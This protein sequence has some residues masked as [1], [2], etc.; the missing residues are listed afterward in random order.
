MI[1]SILSI[2]IDFIQ[3]YR[4]LS[5]IFQ[6]PQKPDFR[7]PPKSFIFRADFIKKKWVNEVP[8]RAGQLSIFDVFDTPFLHYKVWS[9]PLLGSFFIDFLKTLWTSGHTLIF[10]DVFYQVEWYASGSPKSDFYRFF[11]IFLKNSARACFQSFFFIQKTQKCL[12]F[13]SGSNPLVGF[14]EVV[15]F[16]INYRFFGLSFY[17]T[18]P[19]KSVFYNILGQRL[20]NRP[21]L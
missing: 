2:F 16:S 5:P 6:K 15:I 21:F 10:F 12:F 9:N 1:L 4:F 17:V 8:P 20:P 13:N 11:F 7:D 14:W 18:G 19:A 3:N